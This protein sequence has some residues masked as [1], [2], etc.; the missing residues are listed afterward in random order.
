MRV[1]GLDPGVAKAGWAIV[2]DRVDDYGLFSPKSSQKKFNDKLN[3][4]FMTSV[5]FFR[6]KLNSVDAVAW[7]IVPSFGAMA[8]RDRVV[9]VA[10]ALKFAT[11]EIG[12]P[13]V[14]IVP[15]SIK[16]TA[17][18]NAKATKA[19]MKNVALERFPELPADKKLP[20]DIF[21]AVMIADVAR[22]KGEWS[23]E[24]F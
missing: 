20:A 10:T 11:W 24:R 7:E 12:L 18:G 9:G 17:T 21:D 3:E 23:H 4:E 5:R 15:M 8:Q 2:G 22:R 1:L 6:E 14:G 16:K 19:D 13:W